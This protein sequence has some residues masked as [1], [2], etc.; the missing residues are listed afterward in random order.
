MENFC[1]VI[2]VTYFDD[3]I[4]MM[5]LKSRHNW[6]FCHNEFEK[7]TQIQISNIEGYGD[8]WKFV[9]KTMHFRHILSKIQPKYLKLAYY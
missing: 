2:L 3:G 5:S 8:F 6:L 1:D 4:V 7:P 9:T